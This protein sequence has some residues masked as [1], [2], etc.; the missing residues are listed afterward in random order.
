MKVFLSSYCQGW[1]LS[2][3]SISI[4]TLNVEIR[5]DKG[6][7]QNKNHQTYRNFHV[8]MRMTK[9]WR[10]CKDDED[11]WSFVSNSSNPI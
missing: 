9:V 11:V 2:T 7:H 4:L 10:R 6:R 3:S 1:H 8:G 5:K